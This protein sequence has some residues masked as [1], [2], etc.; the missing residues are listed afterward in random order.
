MFR[1]VCRC[2]GEPP[3]TFTWCHPVYGALSAGSFENYS[4]LTEEYQVSAGLCQGINLRS[5]RTISQS[6]LLKGLIS[7][8]L[9][10]YFFELSNVYIL[11]PRNRPCTKKPKE[12]NQN[13]RF[14]LKSLNVIHLSQR[15]FNDSF[16][17]LFLLK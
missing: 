6:F 4:V 10:K 15:F 5:M 13:H 1:V 14:V 2:R 12:R 17:I 11:Y 9:H 3:P 8:N 7:N 16:F